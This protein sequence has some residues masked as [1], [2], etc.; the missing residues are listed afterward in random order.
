MVTPLRVG[1]AGAGRWAVVHH[2]PGLAA[3][4]EAELVAVFDVDAVRAHEVAARFGGIAVAD[5]TDLVERVDAVVVASPPAAHHAAAAA[6][7]DQ[8]RPVLVEKPMT[9]TAADAWDL[10]ARGAA[11]G[12]PVMVGYPLELTS[13]SSHV[14]DAVGDL[15]ELLLIDGIYASAMRHLFDGTW[16]FDRTDP[17][18]VP[19]PETFADPNVSGG[20]QAR[21]QLTHLLASALRAT[22]AQARATAALFRPRD[23][24]IDLHDVVSVDFGQLIGT[25]ASTCALPCGHPPTWELRYVGERGT[26][27]HDLVTGAASVRLA[28]R[29]AVQLPPLAQDERYP[30]QAVVQRFVDVVLGRAENPVPG[31]LGAEVV[32]VLEAAHESVA[33]SGAPVP[34]RRPQAPTDEERR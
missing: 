17:L 18:T 29:D 11:T 30:S 32:S 20:G 19:R 8:G 26:V 15:G 25:F 9:I 34:V 24:G 33:A 5:V 2:L 14:V 10:V 12:T 4:P 21:G 13:T 23:T 1:I 28:D 3:H 31:R 7:L 6:A 16:P 27:V 22:G